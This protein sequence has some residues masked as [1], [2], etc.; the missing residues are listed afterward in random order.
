MKLFTRS[1]ACSN[2]DHVLLEWTGAPYDV[3]V[4]TRAEQDGD[5]YGA[6]NPARTV[7][8]LVDGDTLVVQNAAVM[9]Y[10]ADSYPAAGFWG[11]GSPADRARVVQWIAY[12]N[13]DV[14]P[15]YGPLFSPGAFAGEER[16]GEL[17]AHARER[18]RGIYAKADARLA[19]STWLAGDFRSGGDAYLWI[20]LTWAEKFGV[21]LSGYP[22]LCAFK[23]R[24]DADAGVR[25]VLR[26]VAAAS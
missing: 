25:A 6:V 13:S 8:A 7:P 22:H 23:E 20:T 21:D 14:H 3:E 11:D 4:L 2:A 26:A 19:E 18:I 16:A 5:G 10:I 12:A 24:M 15:A 17:A 1:E 9:S